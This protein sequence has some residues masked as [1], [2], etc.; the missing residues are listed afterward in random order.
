M[1]CLATVISLPACPSAAMP[2]RSYLF[3]KSESRRSIVTLE[4]PRASACL[5][6]MQLFSAHSNS[7]SCMTAPCPLSRIRRCLDVLGPALSCH[8]QR[9]AV[10]CCLCRNVGLQPWEGSRGQRRQLAVGMAFQLRLREAV[11]R[12][13]MRAAEAQTRQDSSPAIK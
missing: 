2:P 11:A 13:S 6:V 4:N 10:C 7:D 9:S 5:G 3:P 8:S 1:L 12:P